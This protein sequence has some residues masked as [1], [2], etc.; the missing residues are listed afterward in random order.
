MQGRVT[1]NRPPY[2]ISPFHSDL[3][4]RRGNQI[5]SAI[6]PYFERD[7]IR[8]RAVSWA[9]WSIRRQRKVRRW[10]GTFWSELVSGRCTAPG[11]LRCGR[12]WVQNGTAVQTR[13]SPRGVDNCHLG[14]NHKWRLQ[15][16]GYFRTSLS[17]CHIVKVNIIAKYILDPSTSYFVNV[18]YG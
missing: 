5:T 2:S 7:G 11:L 15:D 3:G 10:P 17:L 16:F 12:C 1:T 14:A 9:F 6:L 18:I 4:K 8:R 13:R